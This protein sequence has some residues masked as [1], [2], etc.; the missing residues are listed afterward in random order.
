MKSLKYLILTM[1]LVTLGISSSASAVALSDDLL[2]DG[3]E[4]EVGDTV[5]YTISLTAYG[6]NLTDVS[7]YFYVPTTIGTGTCDGVDHAAGGVMIA[8]NMT[9]Y[10]GVT[11][12]VNCIDDP[13]LAYIIQPGDLTDIDG[14]DLTAKISTVASDAGEPDCDQ[15]TKT[16][17]ILP[18]Q[19][20]ID[21]TKEVDCEISKAG[22]QVTYE[23]CV[24][25]CGDTNIVEIV[26]LIDS[27]L[28]DLTAEMNAAIGDSLEPADV[29][30][31]TIDHNIPIDTLED[32]YI[33]EVNVIA[34]DEYSTRTDP[35]FA[36]ASVDLV[37][38]N[39]VVEKSCRQD[40]VEVPSVA[41]FD[42]YVE[43]TGDVCLHF[44]FNELGDPCSFS[45]P[46]GGSGSWE[47]HIDVL[48]QD[49]VTNQILGTVTLLPGV[50]GQC[51]EPCD[52]LPN[53][54]DVNVVAICEVSG[55]ATRTPGF[56]KTHYYIAKHVFENCEDIDPN[57]DLGWTQV[58]NVN[59]MM[60][61]FWASKAHQDKLCQLRIQA[62]FHAMAAIL[63]NCLPDGQG[64]SL[65]GYLSSNCSDFNTTDIPAVLGGCDEEAIKD[66]T[67]C[68][69]GYN[70]EGDEVEVTFPMGIEAYNAQPKYAREMAEGQFPQ[71]DCDAGC[72]VTISTK[73]KG[74][75]KGKGP[76]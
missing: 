56:W 29:C 27:K 4:F 44:D 9:L 57:L 26:S 52:C 73:G 5:C 37:H 43:N 58:S 60:A 51:G 30:C 76:K 2:A 70:E 35:C 21:I 69:A 62:S 49:D 19:P 48:T 7:V 68:L 17:T 53:E 31:I 47:S 20:C 13:N 39:F 65:E 50:D 3:T 28:G 1:L 72:V 42:I 74:G 61:I 63:N 55:G 67:S 11:W 8:E 18:P 66:L 10:D 59:E 45:L 25:N 12:E 6:G 38:P 16:V 15:E 22:D 40:I 41:I 23:I 14:N 46:A 24:E 32:P 34:E 64:L 54:Y 75:G 36:S 33:N 71:T